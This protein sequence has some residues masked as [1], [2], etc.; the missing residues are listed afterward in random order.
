MPGGRSG[1]IQG[2][3]GSALTW[4]LLRGAQE[5]SQFISLVCEPSFIHLPIHSFSQSVFVEYRQPENSRARLWVQI[6]ALLLTS[7]GASDSLCRPA[8]EPWTSYVA[9]VRLS[10]LICKM[11]ALA[12]LYS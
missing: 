10:F 8:V 9:A 12:L 2:R 7:C 4:A 3:V 6:P 1:T 5:S 11:G